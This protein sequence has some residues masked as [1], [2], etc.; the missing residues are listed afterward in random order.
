[1]STL[2]GG[3]CL[4]CWKDTDRELI[5]YEVAKTPDER[6]VRIVHGSRRVASRGR[7]GQLPFGPD[8]ILTHLRSESEQSRTACGIIIAD[9]QVVSP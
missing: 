4:L 8:P 3:G 1:M 2:I 6:K 5:P 9:A 7:N